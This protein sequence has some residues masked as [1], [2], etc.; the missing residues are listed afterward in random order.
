MPKVPADIWK[1]TPYIDHTSSIS[2]RFYNWKQQEEVAE[3][4][5]QDV[6]PMDAPLDMEQDRTDISKDVTPPPQDISF[7]EEEENEDKLDFGTTEEEPSVDPFDQP[8]DLSAD[9]QSIY[10]DTKYAALK[11]EKFN[12]ALGEDSPGFENL[13]SMLELGEDESFR[14]GIADKTTMEKQQAKIEAIRERTKDID[15]PLT[16][17]EVNDLFFMSKVDTSTDPSTVLEELYGSKYV[18]TVSDLPNAGKAIKDG[19]KES[20]DQTLDALDFIA[21]EVAKQEIV[22]DLN[23]D[24]SQ[25][26]EEKSTL[27]VVWDYAETFVPLKSYGNLTNAAENAP[28][29]QVGSRGAN[30]RAIYEYYRTLPPA[31]FK[32][33]FTAAYE[34]IAQSNIVDAQ[35]FLE[36]YL[37]YAPSDEALDDLF[38]YM[39]YVGVGGLAFAGAKAVQGVRGLAARGV[40]RP[41]TPRGSPKTPPAPDAPPPNPFAGTEIKPDETIAVV[42]TNDPVVTVKTAP[43]EIVVNP[44]KIKASWDKKP[45]R[46]RQIADS[47]FPTRDDWY[48]FIVERE[49]VKKFVP[50]E[51]FDNQKNYDQF[52]DNLTLATIRNAEKNAATK[53]VLKDTVKASSFDKVEDQLAQVGEVD[54]SAEVMA[55]K[56]LKE[57]F[58]SQDPF[59]DA[60]DLQNRTTSLFYPHEAGANPGSLSRKQADGITAR[61]YRSAVKLLRAVT[62]N[63]S[64][65][66]MTP[67]ATQAAIE[68]AKAQMVRQFDRLSDAVLDVDQG[69]A[70]RVYTP[71][72]QGV[73]VYTLEYRLGKITK[74]PAA[75]EETAKAGEAE[76]LRQAANKGQK[77]VQPSVGQSVKEPPKPFRNG[78]FHGPNGTVYRVTANNKST[79]GTVMFARRSAPEG[80]TNVY[81][82]GKNGKLKDAETVNLV[83]GTGNRESLW[84]PANE[85]QREQAA[86]LLNELGQ[87]A[88]NS[89]EALAIYKK[90]EDLVTGRETPTAAQKT[91]DPTGDLHLDTVNKHTAINGRILVRDL[92]DRMKS[93]G[94]FTGNL[95]DFRQLVAKWY[96]EKRIVTSRHETTLPKQSPEKKGKQYTPKTDLKKEIGPQPTDANSVGAWWDKKSAILQRHYK[97]ESMVDVGNAAYIPEDKLNDVEY[98]KEFLAVSRVIDKVADDVTRIAFKRLWPDA[99]TNID[100]NFAGLAAQ[101]A[102]FGRN[103]R[104]YAKDIGNGFEGAINSA[105]KEGRYNEAFLRATIKSVVDELDSFLKKPKGEGMDLAK[106]FNI[107]TIR[108]K[109]KAAS[110]ENLPKEFQDVAKKIANEKAKLEYIKAPRVTDDLEEGNFAS[111]FRRDVGYGNETLRNRIIDSEIVYKKE[112]KYTSA[113]RFHYIEPPSGFGPKATPVAPTKPTANYPKASPKNISQATDAL[114]D[115]LSK[116]GGTPNTKLKERISRSIDKIEARVT[117]R[118]LGEDVRGLD[119]AMNTSPYADKYTNV[120]RRK[121]ERDGKTIEQIEV[122]DIDRRAPK[123]RRLTQNE[124]NAYNKLE[125][126]VYDYLNAVKPA[127]RTAQEEPYVVEKKLGTPQATLFD[128]PKQAANY[129]VNLYG[130]SPDQFKILPQGNKFYIS[131]PKVVDETVPMARDLMTTTDNVS[132]RGFINAMFG[133]VR[134]PDE[135]LSKQANQNRKLAAYAPSEMHKLMQE[136]A[137]EIRKMPKQ[138]REEVEELWIANRDILQE[139]SDT[140][141]I[142]R[143]IFYNTFGDFER[144]FQARFDKL[145]TERQTAAYFEY[146]RLY[147]FDYVLRNLGLHRDL[148]RMGLEKTR[149]FTHV[150]NDGQIDSFPSRWFSSRDVDELPLNADDGEDWGVYVYDASARSGQFH[151]RSQLTKDVLDD[152]NTKTKNH[153]YR[154]LELG[155]PLEKPLRQIAG[156]DENVNFLVVKGYEKVKYDWG[157]L[158][159]RPGGHVEYGDLWFTKQPRIRRS[160]ASGTR[161]N[162]YE[163]DT[164]LLNHGTEAEAKIL[165]KAADE[166][167]LMLKRGAP[168]A[169]LEDFLSKNTP[170][171][172]KQWKGFFAERRTPKGDVIPPKFHIDDPFTYTFS[173]RNTFDMDH[174]KA[175]KEGYENFVDAIRSKYNLFAN[176]VDKKYLGQRDPDL[177]AVEI[178]D[179]NTPVMTLVKPRLIDPLDT[180]NSSLANVIRSRYLN[181]YKHFSVESFIQEF[182]DV[183]K[184][185]PEELRRNPVYYLHNPV[186]DTEVTGEGFYKLQAAKNARRAILN[187]LG[188][189]S[190]LGENMY[191]LQ[192]KLVNGIYGQYGQSVANKVVANKLLPFEKD[193]VTFLRSVAFHSQLG[194]FNIKQLFLQA[195]SFVNVMGIEG[196]GPAIRSVPKAYAARISYFKGDDADFI[197]RIAERLDLDVD[198]FVEGY[199]EL[200]KTGFDNVGGEYASRDD[201]FDPKVFTGPVGTFLEKGTFF[202]KEG[203][204]FSRLTAWFTAYDK[205]RAQNPGKI[206]TNSDRNL[207]LDRADLLTANMSRASNAQIQNGIGS[208]PTQYYA[209]QTRL[210]ELMLGKRLTLKEKARLFATYSAMYGVPVGLSVGAIYPF[211]DDFRQSAIERGY[212][213]DDKAVQLF[214]DGLI[215]TA[216]SLITGEQYDFSKKYGP[217]GL[218]VFKD[219]KGL[220]GFGETDKTLLDILIGASGQSLKDNA[221]AL[222]TGFEYITSLFTVDEDGPTLA[223]FSDVTKSISSVNTQLRAWYMYNTGRYFT[224]KEGVVKDDLTGFDAFMLSVFGVVPNEIGDTFHMMDSLKEQKKAEDYAR[225]NVI[226]Y[227][228]QS[229]RY[230]RDGDEKN[231]RLALR[232]A[233]AHLIGGGIKP[234]EYSSIIKEAAKG[235]ESMFEA[236]QKDFIRNAPMDQ[237]QDRANEAIA[238]EKR[239]TVKGF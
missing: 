166:A 201:Y 197:R 118:G 33:E 147:D 45:W 142:D 63:A 206:M 28:Q 102:E 189:D 155:N 94:T 121:V 86:A 163:G 13:Q 179:G 157:V 4:Q 115:L 182:S 158:P 188:T 135:M 113:R 81:Y 192:Q 180:I 3:G 171:T 232:K 194:L 91:P 77:E 152:I 21:E 7:S 145:P 190:P 211:Y 185:S 53:Q 199:M 181:D 96:A 227:F 73:N 74:R 193:P 184:T 214:H 233:K 31:Q 209:Y 108:S 30:R 60:L 44:E 137:R 40:L 219:I 210:A 169:E 2:K 234:N 110:N 140:G 61:A 138:E 112:T 238:H 124:I 14:Q 144:G 174:F 107:T 97:L 105:L 80:K 134:T 222:G 12:F 212:N 117:T 178:G 120:T 59:G 203:E 128:N 46:K 165:S 35:S 16:E 228:R 172:L 49:K 235:N 65:T 51:N 148:G 24:L 213:M 129:G 20:P 216:A 17:D 183:M 90:I 32:K 111:E 8:L 25:R 126:E 204:R 150:D 215:S 29:E 66:R 237:M 93:E 218:Q 161:R 132:D 231:A 62:N 146:R 176:G 67:E 123:Q 229:I 10:R 191:W 83:A 50:R 153:G 125:A 18:K 221:K 95:A 72:Q 127:K 78:F 149:I 47:E 82:I 57:K 220:L 116:L 5:F 99:P 195:Q 101:E 168:D 159:Y 187:F 162:I 55:H 205:W 208:I 198:N 217:S 226:K 143:G 175:T 224:S 167:R 56:R 19:I 9:A 104:Q 1:H 48:N 15:R 130:L 54:L 26:Y 85:K 52:L 154:I 98:I 41:R 151:L 230:Q 122:S 27:G 37:T 79:G 109:H 58:E 38:G 103:F 87:S 68:A 186:W 225:K 70:F 131:I 64:V 11:A 164:S 42:P 6:I 34:R 92:Y 22:H 69:G 141:K 239:N 207:V 23:K 136:A 177:P 223:D 160:D 71:E 100:D 133:L 39:D 139:D 75:R 200:R 119:E 36:G 170:W 202:F 196:I 76:G 236:I 173:G 88:V 156:T 84:I 43:G 89:P 114:T 106:A